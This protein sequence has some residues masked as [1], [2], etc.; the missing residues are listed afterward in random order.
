MESYLGI[1]PP[2][3]RHGILQDVHWSIGIMGYFPTY[4]LGN[5]L[6]V[7]LFDRAIQDVPSIPDDI[8][9]GRFAPLLAWLRTNVHQYG[10]KY[11]PEEL[12]QRATGSSLTV[13]PYVKYLKTKLGELYG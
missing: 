13:A 4:S 7:Q 2:D 3:N 11:L 1:T 10:R 12:I 9:N 5:I 8:E 6:S